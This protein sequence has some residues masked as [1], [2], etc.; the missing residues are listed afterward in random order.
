MKLKFYWPPELADDLKEAFESVHAE[1]LRLPLAEKT[2]T[3]L[4][5][6]LAARVDSVLFLKD[7]WKLR[8]NIMLDVREFVKLRNI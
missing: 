2:T 6:A 1:F 4:E 5:I 7:R 8:E 3:D